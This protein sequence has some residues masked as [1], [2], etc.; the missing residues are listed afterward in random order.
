G[1]IVTITSRPAQSLFAYLILHAGVAHRREKLAG[2]L[3]PDSLEE[4]ARGNLRHALWQIRKSLPSSAGYLLA[5]DLS[6]AFNASAE[7]WLD[8]AGLE[9]L[10]ETASAD[11]LIAV[12][13]EYQGELLPGFYDEW[14]VLER[15][16]LYSIFEHHM[17]RLMSLLQ[18]EHR[19]LD[20]LEWGEQWIKLGQKPEPAYRALMSAHAAKGDMSKVV[21]TYERC[22]KSLREYGIAPSE[23]TKELYKNL[24]LGKEIPETVPASMKS[25]AKETSSNIPVPL[26]SFI[27]REEE[28]KEIRS[29]LTTS[30]LLT[31]TGPGGVGKTR[32]A[33][34]TA[35]DSIKS[36]KD[37][38]VWVS[39]VGLS[40]ENLIP[41][42]IAQSLNVGE[43]SQESVIET[44]KVYLKSKELL[45]VLDNCEHL[46]RGSAVYAEQLL[47]VCPKLK[48]LATSI[49]ALGLFNE[50]TWQVPSL[51]L[52]KMWEPLSANEFQTFASIELFAER[53]YAVNINFALTDQNINSVAQ[54]C[55]RLD[56]IPLA[57]ELAAARTKVLSVDE[58]ATRLDDRFSLLTAG[59]RTA[60]P[61]HQTLRATIDWSYE[62]LTE[63]ERILF[64]R[65]AVFAGG[66]TLDAA[67]AVCGQG[68]LKRNDILDLLGRLVDKSLV[69]VDQE[70]ST[71]ETRY[72]LLETIRQYALEKLIEIREAPAMRDQHLYY[73][74]ALAEKAEPNLTG[75][76]YARWFRRLDKELDNI[77]AAI[78]WSTNTGKADAALRI[79][80]SLGYFWFA[81]RQAGSEW[82]DWMQRALARPEGKE[83]TLTRAKALNA[84]GF[85]YFADLVPTDRRPELE[86]ALS[87]AR[88]FSD[89]WNIATALRNLGL[90]ENVSGNY[91]EAHTYLEQSLVIWRDM[92]TAGKLGRAWT[93]IF[94]GD[95]AVNIEEVET[96]RGLYEEV[97]LILRETGDLNFLAYSLR[98]LA[99][100]LWREGEYEKAVALCKE[101]LNLNEQV[102][103]PRG[104]VACLAG[105][106][107]IAAAQ[108]DYRRAAQMMATVEEQVTFFGI[109]LIYM[110][111]QEYERNLA[112]I[113]AKL[114]EKSLTKSWAKGKG[115]AL[116]EA[117]AFALEEA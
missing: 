105:F 26:T 68:E 91:L 5:D 1:M 97:V 90:M 44:L 73:Y 80:G 37:G 11:E 14:V 115:M 69:V 52:P 56:G 23:Q 94:L 111:Q 28:L 78:E 33:I 36:F 51:P 29:F 85:M 57:I 50:T 2:M 35:C 59:S 107:A 103:S 113:R 104:V 63:P 64:R 65:L 76:E 18:N 7:Y 21:A 87:I 45:L 98:R 67:E 79:A 61:R 34:Q 12:F 114:D 47:A 9:K 41:Q 4:T 72:H 42:E 88:E 92:G 71:G 96:A 25:F 15:E 39:L 20:V 3:W 66:F 31:L 30:R 83:R 19:W 106:A 108:Q 32:L 93:L 82:Y 75:S 99:Q 62:L 60:I 13:A 22:V 8:A 100:L 102:G 117:I 24:K 84:I 112:L 70:S 43:L 54:I 110:D 58:I 86:E 81:H 53:A 49:E 27:G 74:L 55:H 16:H 101:S 40:D 6:I 95:V 38:V 17:A 10:S 46:I 48:I 77:R 116:E 89:P 109:R